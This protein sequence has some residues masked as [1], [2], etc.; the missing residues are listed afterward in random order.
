VLFTEPQC[1]PLWHFPFSFGLLCLI[2][3]FCYFYY[4]YVFVSSGS[5]CP[6]LSFGT[7]VGR[8][9]WRTYCSV[10]SGLPCFPWVEWALEAGKI[11]RQTDKQR[12]REWDGE[13]LHSDSEGRWG[14]SLVSW[15][16]FTSGLIGVLPGAQQYRT[17]WSAGGRSV[18]LSTSSSGR[19]ESSELRHYL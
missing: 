2:Q 8:H 11:E 3:F 17:A 13:S 10:C 7:A 18:I 15:I 4:V 16:V 6:N 14:N 9:T 5:V 12:K 1:W 19:R